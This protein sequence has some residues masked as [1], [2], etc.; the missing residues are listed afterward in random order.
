MTIRARLMTK[1]AR[2]G[3]LLRL[4]REEW[5]AWDEETRGAALRVRIRCP[6]HGRHL[7]GGVYEIRGAWVVRVASMREPWGALAGTRFAPD[8]HP[9]DSRP[10]VP[11]GW[12]LLGNLEQVL[13]ACCPKEG[14][15]P[16]IA[17]IA[18]VELERA[19]ARARATGDTQTL[20]TRASVAAAVEP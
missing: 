11:R 1:V 3:E 8:A 20:R 16:D 19:A 14:C 4:C 9:K 5:E 2:R 17:P 7:V 10:V 18:R 6:N 12:S 15:V 13:G